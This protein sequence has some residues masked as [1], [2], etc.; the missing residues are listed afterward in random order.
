MDKGLR[1]PTV[2]VVVAGVASL[3]LLCLIIFS[4][5]Q[6]YQLG[7]QNRGLA[8][9]SIALA[10]EGVQTH[11][12]LCA[13][14]TFR[15]TQEDGVKRDIAET[16]RFLKLTIEERVAEYGEAFGKLPDAIVRKGLADDR[17]KLA[18][19]KALL[20]AMDALKCGNDQR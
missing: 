15:L 13:M 14:R 10:Q 4:I 5:A 17:I 18:N 7:N 3:L 9:Q 20:V 16:E 6:N 19:L 12:T 11:T 2:A 8:H 1:R